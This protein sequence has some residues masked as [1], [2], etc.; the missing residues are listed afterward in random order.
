MKSPESKTSTGQRAIVI[1]IAIAMVVSTIALYMGIILSSGNSDSS[2]SSTVD[3]E[4]EARF[5]ELYADYQVKAQAQMTEL[6]DQYFDTF[7]PYLS[8]VKSYNAAAVN[9]LTVTDLKVGTGTEVTEGFSDYSA[10]YIGWLSDETV[11]DSSFDSTTDPTSLYTPLAGGNMIEGW[12]EGII[13]MKI[14]GV[15]EIAM[16]SDLAYG[17]T[18]QGTI[19]ANS[20]L[21]FVVMLIP[22]VEQIDWSDEMYELY[23]EI[24]GS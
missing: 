7:E 5:E 3:P 1:I 2:T 11:F 12:N 17:D 4:K 23:Y 10:Y 13:G 22:P 9:D 21:K 18:E 15:R 19:P 16:P 20:P 14:G 8:R 6:S 24:Y